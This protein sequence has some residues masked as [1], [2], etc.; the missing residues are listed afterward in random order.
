MKKLYTVLALSLLSIGAFAQCTITSGPT[1]TP[2]GLNV[3][4]TGTGTGA[5]VPQYIYDWGDA[6]NPGS[7][8]TS[9]HTYAS[10]GTYTIC[11]YYADITDPQNCLDSNC[12]SVTVS[13]VGVNDPTVYVVNVQATPNPFS[14]QLTINLTMANAEMVEVSVYDI[15]GKQ[16]AVLKNGMMGIGS[17][18]IDWK[19][20]GLSA[21]VYFLQVK[22]NSA[23]LTKKIVYTQN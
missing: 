12:T 23:L 6:T 10:S 9:T 22:T 1:V 14:S 4:V 21:G 18:V 3:S 11:M 19:P 17:N 20:A 2:S 5:V 16:V 7:S 8:Q 13:A 15:T